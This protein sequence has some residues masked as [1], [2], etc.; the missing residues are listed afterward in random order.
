METEDQP[1][2]LCY[3]TGKLKYKN[4]SHNEESFNVCVDCYVKIVEE[5]LEALVQDEDEREELMIQEFKKT[6]ELNKRLEWDFER[7]A[8][9]D[10]RLLS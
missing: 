2:D 6:E 4:I 8:L 3:W 5:I 1:C 10:S 7:P 9:I